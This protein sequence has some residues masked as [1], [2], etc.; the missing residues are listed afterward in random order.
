MSPSHVDTTVLLPKLATLIHIDVC[1]LL[2]SPAL[3]DQVKRIWQTSPVIIFRRQL[4]REREQVRFSGMFGECME[5][6]RKDN[7][8]P[9]EPKIVYFSTLKYNDGRPVGA[10]AMVTRP[11][12]IRTRPIQPGLR[13][14]RCSMAS[15]CHATVAS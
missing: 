6:H 8:S 7:V 4:M 11:T 2:E 13:L 1:E 10:S 15:R 12:G 9:Y 3:V 5:I 14:A